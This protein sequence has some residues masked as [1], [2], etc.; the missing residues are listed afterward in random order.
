MSH[1]KPADFADFKA[2]VAAVADGDRHACHVLMTSYEK[3]ILVAS[4]SLLRRYYNTGFDSVDLV[5]SVHRRLLTGIRDRQFNPSN[6]GDLLVLV[7]SLLKKRAACLARGAHRRAS[8][9]AAALESGALRAPEASLVRP[10]D[11]L[12]VEDLE[13]F[14]GPVESTD[15]RIVMMRFEGYNDKEI[16]ERL[17]LSHGNVRIRLSRLRDRLE[18][19]LDE[20]RGPSGG[21]NPESS[22]G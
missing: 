9:L 3:E 13:Q 11:H 22:V 19:Y 2:L 10:L 21:A 6:V 1:S 5:Q 16:A 8:L 12:L 17:G 14:I 15:R 7:Q 18:W 4:R 20:N